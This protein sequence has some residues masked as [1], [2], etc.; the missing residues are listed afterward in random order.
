MKRLIK[1]TIIL[2]VFLLVNANTFA[3]PQ[4]EMGSRFKPEFNMSSNKLRADSLNCELVGG[5]FPGMSEFI[6][7]YLGSHLNT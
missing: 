5:W 6:Y 4:M 3:Q 7:A 1:I 2:F